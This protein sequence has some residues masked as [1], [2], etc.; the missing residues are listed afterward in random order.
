MSTGGPAFY[1]DGK[2]TQ[3]HAVTL[4]LTA[5]ALLVSAADGTTLA[6]W[7]YNELEQSSS[8]EGV[9]RIARL[10]SHDLA[11]IE[12]RDPVLAKAIDDLSI[13]LDRSG[14]TARRSRR[15][16]VVLAMAA[17]ASLMLV[18]IYGIPALATQLAPYVP[19]AFEKRVG[20]VVDKQVRAVLGPSKKG[21]PFECGGK[22]GEE[23][24]IA[25]L[26][27]MADRLE[28]AAKL[29][30]P[31]RV[32]VIRRKEANAVALPGGYIYVFDGLIQQAES[33]DEVAGVI[34]HEI[35]H[36]AHRDGMRSVMQAGGLTFLFGLVLGDFVGGGA[37][38]V[39]TR[40]VLQLAYSREVEAAADLYAVD[41][42]GNAGGN[43]RALGTI[44]KRIAGKE[45]S[46]SI[47]ANHPATPERARA[48][49][50][51]ARG[52]P[53]GEVLGADD[54]AA[55]RRVCAGS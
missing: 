32:Q 21:D 23:A 47:L 30:I 52:E 11:R 25:A 35:G 44:L 42:I 15:K 6:R 50:A 48:I 1:F 18:G 49:D 34:A 13:P 12:V 10:R 41:L 5:T 46:T 36:V 9:L 53:K 7:P 2:S 39:A 43:P 16:V 14:L 27:K 54:W 24:G 38:V 8:S 51:A 33:A 3:R 28:Q 31:L 17:V 22:A 40:A 55:L 19:Y 45:G 29:P 4:E 26:K 20:A 37:V